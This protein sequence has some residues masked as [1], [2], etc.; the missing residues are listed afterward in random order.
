MSDRKVC[1]ITGATSGIGEATAELMAEYGWHVVLI[2]RNEKRGNNIIKRIQNKGGIAEFY[3][4]DLSVK[5]DVEKLGKQIKTLGHIEMLFN[6]AGM[7]PESKEIELIDECEWDET[8][9]NNLQSVVFMSATLKA[10]LFQSKGVIINNASI[11]GMQSYIVGRS[12]AYS[13]S[14]AAVIQLT[15]Q[16]AKNYAQ[17]GVRVNCICPG[18]ID[19]PLL[20]NRDRK[21]YAKRVPLGYLGEPKDVATVVCFLASDDARYITGA[22]LP[23]DGG[24]SI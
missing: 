11:A 2:G 8:F 10:L 24:V 13:A 23:V 20:G 22:I 9:K 12:Y 19:T 1:V 18:I 14:K 5:A 21:E 7:M 3:A 17:Y 6:N 15:R 16:M 4:C